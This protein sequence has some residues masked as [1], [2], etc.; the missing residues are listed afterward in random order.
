MNSSRFT[1]EASIMELYS[2]WKGIREKYENFISEAQKCE[3][4]ADAPDD[5]MIAMDEFE[6]AAKCTYDVFCN[7]AASDT[8]SRSLLLLFNEVKAFSLSGNIKTYADGFLEFRTSVAAALCDILTENMDY[9]ES[10]RLLICLGDTCKTHIK[11]Y[12]ILELS[13]FSFS[14][15]CKKVALN[16]A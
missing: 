14:F 13:D 7:N 9:G 15:L 6:D 5:Q 4:E 3:W 8:L 1:N 2:K 11:G 10:G 12:Y 16:N